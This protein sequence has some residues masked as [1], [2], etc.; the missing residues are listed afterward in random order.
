VRSGGRVTMA[1]TYHCFKVAEKSVTK[2]LPK[3][4]VD[5]Q[6]SNISRDEVREIQGARIRGWDKSR[7]FYLCLSS[8]SLGKGCVNNLD[9]VRKTPKNV[10]VPRVGCSQTGSLLSQDL[11]ARGT[12]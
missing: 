2:S 7:S 6:V 5:T 11:T 1:L 4:H 8:V 12:P 3:P 9:R 10:G